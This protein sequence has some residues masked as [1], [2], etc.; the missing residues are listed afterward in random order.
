MVRENVVRISNFCRTKDNGTRRRRCRRRRHAM[1]N[2][3]ED[4]FGHSSF[5]CEY[6][7]TNSFNTSGTV[8]LGNVSWNNQSNQIDETFD[9][10]IHPEGTL[11]LYQDENYDKLL[12]PSLDDKSVAVSVSI[13]RCIPEQQQHNDVDVDGENDGETS[14]EYATIYTDNVELLLALQIF[15]GELG[16]L[17]RPPN[18]EG[19]SHCT[20]VPVIIRSLNDPLSLEVEDECGAKM[21]KVREKTEG[22]FQVYVSPCVAATL[23]CYSCLQISMGGLKLSKLR[24]QKLSRN[25]CLSSFESHQRRNN[26]KRG[27]HQVPLATK[28]TIVEISPPPDD[29]LPSPHLLLDDSD[30]LSRRR[31]LEMEK[32]RQTQKIQDYFYKFSGQKKIALLRLFTAGIIFAIIN[33]DEKE[34]ENSSR[35]NRALVRFY[36]VVEIESSGDAI[37]D[38]EWLDDFYWMSPDTNII[39]L[40]PNEAKCLAVDYLPRISTTLTFYFSLAKH[41]CKSQNY[42]LR[43]LK[44]PNLVEILESVLSISGKRSATNRL[45]SRA[46]SIYAGSNT[47]I[48]H[49]I[50]REDNHIQ[51]CLDSVADI[52][53]MNIIHIN[54]LSAFG[55]RQKR[56][57]DSKMQQNIVGAMGDKISGLKLA[58]DVVR[59]TAPCIVNICL[60][61]EIVNTDDMESR[62]DEE[63]RI[64]CC[65]RE[66]IN[67]TKE[68]V[69]CSSD[70]PA[71]I[72]L[73]SE[74]KVQNGPLA[75]ALTFDSIEIISPDIQYARELWNDPETFQEVQK[76]LLGKSAAEI[77]LLSFEFRQKKSDAL[78]R[79]K[80]FSPMVTLISMQEDAFNTRVSMFDKNS[81]KLSSK[82]IPDIKWTDVGGL[83]S[84]REEIIDAIEL[85]LKYPDFFKGSRRGGILLFGAPGCGKTL[86]AKA[87]AS[88][89]GLPFLSVKGP[90]LLGSY[91]GESEANI[92]EAFLKA[93]EAA[94]DASQKCGEGAAILFFDEIDSL[95]P[96]RGE[97]GDGG[98]VMERV[99]ST[100]LGELDKAG[101]GGDCKDKSAHVFVIGA[102]NRPDLLDPSLL[103]PGR[104]DRLVYLGLPTDRKDRIS[105]LAAQIRNFHLENDMDSLMMAAEVIDS[106]PSSLSGA[107]FSSIASGALMLALQRVCNEADTEMKGFGKGIQVD[108]GEVLSSW[109]EQKL[110]ARVSAADFI[111]AA[112]T[113]I[114]SVSEEDFKKYRDMK[115]LYMPQSGKP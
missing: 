108:I 45:Q 83:S 54:G 51:N 88:E 36:K 76:I 67:A 85:P 3:S 96:R 10:A 91:V 1:M 24:T 89:C 98:G 25:D 4:S 84:V 60:D 15:E 9:S 30:D 69:Q 82:L 6:D 66:E 63:N 22:C 2:S 28:A 73:S 86:V 38:N 11:D 19:G 20:R 112:A 52:A 47:S 111:A 92:R 64:L 56:F 57:L 13:L 32:N 94:L 46:N 90:E 62:Q 17:S 80:K 93:R 87:V 109:P 100:I 8:D 77:V 104:F 107:D 58:F 115:D 78:C 110:I 43:H 101:V 53:G 74:Q 37:R 29:F 21:P 42:S 35:N 103:R 72:I 44:H 99:V 65:I 40:P 113:V 5:E 105:I 49:I 39:L 106:I 114:P 18:F 26:E 71:I 27:R 41:D 12:E 102:T 70:S 23:G 55:F 59:N 31:N 14:D 79:G 16:I 95:A 7:T 48:L 68:A 61:D 75:S 81:E 33:N 50:G 34:N 97:L